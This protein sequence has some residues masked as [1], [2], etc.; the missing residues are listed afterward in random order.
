VDVV[1]VVDDPPEQVS[2]EAQDRSPRRGPRPG[3]SRAAATRR[4]RSRRRLLTLASALVVAAVVVT[5]VYY[6]RQPAASSGTGP[7]TTLQKGE[8]SQ[9]PDACRAVPA[10]MLT[11]LVGTAPKL[12]RPQPGQCSFT[13]DAKSTFRELNVL[14]QALQPNAGYGNGS[15]TANA[16]YNFAQK[17][18][19]LAKPP[20]HT[21]EPPAKITQI[22]GIGDAAFVAVQVFHVG[23][24]AVTNKVTVIVRYKNVLITTFLQGNERGGTSASTGSLQAGVL[25]ITRAVLGAV[26]AQPATR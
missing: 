23:A 21:P 7:I 24:G 17:R 5:A 2:A 1:D 18:A 25:S 13:V 11:E 20:R 19:Y 16:T 26:K 22:G 15:A 8:Y 10:T 4:R 6:L 3:R 14:I 9:V 12:L